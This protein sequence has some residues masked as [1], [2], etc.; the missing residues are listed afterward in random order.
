MPVLV[1]V[2]A[3]DRRQCPCL[4]LQ[5]I[6]GNARA[7]ACRR[8]QAMPVLVLAGE[9]RQTC[10]CPCLCL[11][12]QAIVGKPA[13]GLANGSSNGNGGVPSCDTAPLLVGMV[14]KACQG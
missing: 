2:L 10:L 4:C 12:L 11:C 13:E 14:S 8:S 3:G 9:R 7:C 6:V 5:A 1:L